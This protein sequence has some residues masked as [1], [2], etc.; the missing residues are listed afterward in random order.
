V[1]TDALSREG[2]P[3]REGDLSIESHGMEPIPAEAR[4]G[5]PVEG[6]VAHRAAR[7]TATSE[8]IS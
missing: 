5:S 4:Y 7:R 6:R 8:S 1:S 2:M 3:T